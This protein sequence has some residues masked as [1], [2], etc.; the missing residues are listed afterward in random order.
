MRA[1]TI[2]QAEVMLRLRVQYPELIA[3]AIPNGTWF[4]G[5]DRELVKRT[6]YRMKQNGLLTPGAGDI[7]IAGQGKAAFVEIKVPDS[8][9]LLGKRRTAG[10]LSVDQKVFR[11]SCIASGTPYIVAHSWEEVDAAVRS[12]WGGATQ[13]VAAV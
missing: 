8:R 12:I 4:A 6:L 1:E 3:A 11:D 7:V 5:V 9:D 10:R 13:R 2:L